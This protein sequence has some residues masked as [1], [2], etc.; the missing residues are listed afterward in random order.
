MDRKSSSQ[1]IP[2]HTSPVV[3]AWHYSSP[4][5]SISK[6]KE[7]CLKKVSAEDLHP[8]RTLADVE[9]KEIE[10]MAK[11]LGVD[12]ETVVDL[13]DVCDISNLEVLI[14]ETLLKITKE[15]IL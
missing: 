10:G 14:L 12:N 8:E 13:M 15:A 7:Q 9:E 3:E 4:L 6:F 2:H 1:E 11:I 5:I